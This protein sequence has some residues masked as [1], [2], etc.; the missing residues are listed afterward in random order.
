M[1][2]PIA[3]PTLNPT[4]TIAHMVDFKPKVVPSLRRMVTQLN[5]LSY[6]KLP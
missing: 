2:L 4:S 1:Y 3:P 6:M 5:Y